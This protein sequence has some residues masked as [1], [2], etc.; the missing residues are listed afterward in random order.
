MRGLIRGLSS[1]EFEQAVLSAYDTMRG[2]GVRVE[3]LADFPAPAGVSLDEI[4]DTLSAIRNESLTDW[5]FAQQEHLEAALEGAERILSADSP[6]AAL[7]AIAAFTC[8][9]QKCKRG[10]NAYNLLKRMREQIEEAEYALI[11]ALYAPQRE[12]LI[13]ILRRFDRLYRERKAAGRRARFRRPRR[14]HRPSARRS[15][16]DP[17]PPA[18]R[19]STTS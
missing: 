12:L 8:N 14:V 19:S 3:Q 4:N 13:E 10:T 18:A 11:T 7:H 6:L 9:L 17:R 5:S 2:A 1:F 15:R 16:R